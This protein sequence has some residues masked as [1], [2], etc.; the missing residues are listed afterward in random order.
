MEPHKY[1]WPKPFYSDGAIYDYSD[2]DGT[3]YKRRLGR[4]SPVQIQHRGSVFTVGA[5]MDFLNHVLERGAGALEWAVATVAISVVGGLC[6]YLVIKHAM[7]LIRRWLYRRAARIAAAPVALV[8]SALDAA[9]ATATQAGA[10]VAEQ[11]LRAAENIA[12]VASFAVGH[13]SDASSRVG[14]AAGVA[15]EAATPVISSFASKAGAAAESAVS[16]AREGIGQAT[17]VIKSAALSAAASMHSGAT[18]LAD[19]AVA[20]APMAISALASA[21]TATSDAARSV[22]ARLGTAIAPTDP[23]PKDTP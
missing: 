17:P 10:V 20:A 5:I 8:N 11:Y 3:Q 4:G 22:R 15:V 18:D 19:R 14:T 21:Q 7:K 1:E 9:V 16:I 6:C 13:I 12:P 23:K 2:G